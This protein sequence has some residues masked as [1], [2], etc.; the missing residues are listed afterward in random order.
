MG[1]KR[2]YLFARGSLFPRWLRVY[3]QRRSQQQF[4]LRFL[5]E[6]SPQLVRAHVRQLVLVHI[7]PLACSKTSQPK[8]RKQECQSRTSDNARRSKYEYLNSLNLH[9]AARG[10]AGCLFGDATGWTVQGLARL[11]IGYAFHALTAQEAYE[12]Y[13][14][15]SNVIAA[16]TTI[17]ACLKF[18]YTLIPRLLDSVQSPWKRHHFDRSFCI[19]RT[20]IPLCLSGLSGLGRCRYCVAGRRSSW[21]SSGHGDGDGG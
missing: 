7:Y 12:S 2:I 16:A 3:C 10:C 15:T 9:G 19:L 5:L 4:R 17:G 11:C 6:D 8:R 21:R 14:V 13:G 18:T 20:L 1:R